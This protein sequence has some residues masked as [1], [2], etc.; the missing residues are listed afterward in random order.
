VALKDESTTKTEGKEYI[1][2]HASK[3][4]KTLRAYWGKVLRLGTWGNNSSSLRSCR[5]AV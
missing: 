1:T 4:K 5:K 3:R 2:V